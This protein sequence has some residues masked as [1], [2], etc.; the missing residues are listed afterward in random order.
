MLLFKWRHSIPSSG[1]SG[2]IRLPPGYKCGN[3]LKRGKKK[4]RRDANKKKPEGRSMLPVHIIMGHSLELTPSNTPWLLQG[5]DVT[6]S[7][8]FIA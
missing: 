1:N 3:K 5:R 2:E 7:V 8:I 6:R 4:P